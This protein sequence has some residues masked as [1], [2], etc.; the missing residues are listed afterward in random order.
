MPRIVLACGELVFIGRFALP[1]MIQE[2]V[3]WNDMIM[4]IGAPR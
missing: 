3:L 2:T 4:I 1:E